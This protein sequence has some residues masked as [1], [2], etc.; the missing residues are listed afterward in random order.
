MATNDPGKNKEY[1]KSY[2]GRIKANPEKYAEFRAKRNAYRKQKYEESQEGVTRESQ[3]HSLESQVVHKDKP[4]IAPPPVKRA[5]LTY[6]DIRQRAQE[7]AAIM[8]FDG[9][10]SRARAESEATK[11][12]VK[13]FGDKVLEIPDLFKFVEEGK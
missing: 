11:E 9:G 2:Y 10:L 13:E 8:E 5:Q 7:I 3:V 4:V 12:M 6:G 1:C